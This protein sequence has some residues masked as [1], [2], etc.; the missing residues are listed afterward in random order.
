MISHSKFPPK[1][2]RRAA[3]IAAAGAL[4][5]TGF[6]LSAS[7]PAEAR[8]C[9]FVTTHWGNVAKA[10]WKARENAIAGIGWKVN[11]LLDARPIG[12]VRITSCKRRANGKWQCRASQKVN[13]C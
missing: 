2:H 8:R 6:F 13:R 11:V 12:P 7:T 5:M 4:T 9:T 1:F 3:L 10:K